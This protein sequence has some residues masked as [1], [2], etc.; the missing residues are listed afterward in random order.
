MPG[1]ITNSCS[2]SR[3]LSGRHQIDVACHSDV[4]Q[5]FFLCRALTS[6]SW[7]LEALTHEII[8]I[9][10]SQREVCVNSVARGQYP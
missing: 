6:K 8:E 10:E 1:A 5:L 7:L 4:V 9:H 3:H 2:S